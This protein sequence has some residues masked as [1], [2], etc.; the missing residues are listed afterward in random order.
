MSGLDSLLAW[1][2]GL[3][4]QSVAD[5]GRHYAADA[6]FQDPFNEVEGVAAIERIFRHMFEQ[7]DTPRF[8]VVERIVAGRDAVV[9]WE[10]RFRFR[11]WRRGREQCLRGATHLRFDAAGR[12]ALHR[13]YWDAAGELYAK[14][15]VLGAAMRWL[16]RRLSA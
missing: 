11:G 8:R 14:L 10:M 6:R 4:P 9:I 5:I 15:P 1:F 3:G 12:V 13:D 2:E 16:G 7:L